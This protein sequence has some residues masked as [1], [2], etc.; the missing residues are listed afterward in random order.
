MRTIRRPPRS[1]RRSFMV[2]GSDAFRRCAPL[3]P[4]LVVR[5]MGGIH[6]TMLAPPHV[7]ELAAMVAAAA[8][9]CFASELGAPLRLRAHEG[10]ARVS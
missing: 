6:E 1:R 8:Q 4:D 7:E 9:D 2:D 3:M 5:D 10:A